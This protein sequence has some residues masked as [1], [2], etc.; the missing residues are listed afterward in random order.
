[1]I[2]IKY[3]NLIFCE[4]VQKKKKKMSSAEIVIGTSNILHLLMVMDKKA[5]VINVLCAYCIALPDLALP[6]VGYG[7]PKANFTQKALS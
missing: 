1:M 3:Q 6:I 7:L 4:K 2:H 5:A